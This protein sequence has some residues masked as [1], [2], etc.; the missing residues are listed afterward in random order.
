[1]NDLS[2]T[3]AIKAVFGEKAYQIP[4]SS[5]KAQTGHLIAAAAGPRHPRCSAAAEKHWREGHKA[6]CPALAAARVGLGGR[7]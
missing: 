1:M 6:E 3:N 5:T 2:E 4:V 7:R